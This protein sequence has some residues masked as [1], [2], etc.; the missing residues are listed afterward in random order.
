[1]TRAAGS[2]AHPGGPDLSDPRPRPA[3]PRVRVDGSRLVDGSGAPVLLRGVGLGGWLTMENFIT[4]Y[5]ATE[6]QM[7]RA[8]R[9]VLGD[10]AYEAFFETF[11]AEFFADDDAAHLASLGVNALR[12]PFSYFH[13]EDDARP[14]QIKEDGFRHLDRVVETCAR[15]GIWTILDLHAAPGWQN[16]HWHSDN[17]TGYATFWRHPHFQDRVIHLW[18]A[19]AD[20]Y[21]DQPWVA[22]YNPLNEPADHTGEAIGPFYAR[23]ENAVRAVDPDHVLFLDGNRYSTDFSMFAEP[24]DNAVWTAHD[25]ALPG[26]ANPSRYPGETRGTWFDRGVVEETFLKRTRVM[27]ETGTPIWVGEWGPI[28][29]GDAERVEGAYRV[30]ADQLDVYR[31]HGASWSLWTYKDIGAQGF[32]Y[33]DP[34]SPYLERIRPALDKKT[35]LGTDSWGGSEAEIRHV[36][37]PLEQLVATEY[38]DFDPFPWG[39]KPWL[40]VLVRHI[41][42]AEPL[43]DEYAECFRGLDADGAAELARSFRFD[44]CVERER[45]SGILRDHL[46]P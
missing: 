7:R 25:Y 9:R 12:V 33:T 38:P 43:V 1:M 2:S 40:N 28:Y 23:L 18:E 42:L 27:R 30:L 15:H 35:R 13:L 14:F 46:L 5:P 19:V 32:V 41:L 20:R 21:R 3:D 26:I 24:F 16:Q 22:G 17:P 45:L 37:E 36:L 4:G 8:V 39:T 6:S 34:A 29:V 44:R 31:E 11:L 10:E